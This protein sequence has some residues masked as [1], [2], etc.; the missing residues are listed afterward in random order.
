[1]EEFKDLYVKA[2]RTFN[3]EEI[4]GKLIGFHSPTKKMK[5]NGIQVGIVDCPD[6]G[7]CFDVYPSSIIYLNKKFNIYEFIS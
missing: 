4:F 6:Y 2:I 5:E 7:R 3:N 1:M